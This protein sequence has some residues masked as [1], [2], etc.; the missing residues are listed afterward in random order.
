MRKILKFE[1]NDGMA[2]NNNCRQLG[3]VESLLFNTG[4]MVLV[5]RAGSQ[6]LFQCQQNSEPL[7]F[8]H[9][10]DHIARGIFPVRLRFEYNLRDDLAYLKTDHRGV[11]L[12]KKMMPD[13]F[14]E[15]DENTREEI[16]ESNIPVSETKPKAT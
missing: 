16:Y 13:L 15:I 9:D 14:T 7:I 11:S 4:Q 2:N 5:Q 10:Y 8:I 3:M 1:T 6:R 12:L